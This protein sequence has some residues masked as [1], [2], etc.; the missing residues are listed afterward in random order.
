M[1]SDSELAKRLYYE[2]EDYLETNLANRRFK[3]SDIIPLINKLKNN[4]KFK[5]IK[6]GTS[7]EGRDIFLISL[8]SGKTKIF[9]WSQMHGDEATATMAIFDILNFL[10]SKNGFTELIN[11]FEKKLTI[12]FMPMLNPDGAEIFQRRNALGID[13]NRD[14]A[15][16]QSDEAKILMKYLVELKAD[17]GFNLHDQSTRYSVGKTFKPVTISF[18]AP[19]CDEKGKMNAVRNDA[20]RLI[21]KLYKL[22]SEFIP[23][24]IAKYSDE[25]EP[26]AFGDFSQKSGT[27]TILLESGGWKNDPEKQFI[28]KLNFIAL[29]SSFKSLAEKS[30]KVEK[31]SIYDSIPK[32]KEFLRDVIFRNISVIRNGKKYLIDLSVNLEEVNTRDSKGFYYTSVIEDI[33]DLSALFGYEDHDFKGLTLEYGKTYTEKSYT[34]EELLCL[35]FSQFYKKGF[36]NVLIKSSEFREFSKYPINLV[37][38]CTIQIPNEI[39]TNL[40]A[41][42]IFREK[43]QV[44]Y[45]VVNGF[46][47]SIDNF[48]GEIKNGIV[49]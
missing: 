22:L 14:A 36:T 5:V 13:I 48:S 8:G 18:L 23:G 6:A 28:R 26:R 9:L 2:H 49:Y 7:T 38:D 31:I 11:E 4:N 27:S 10:S 29:L 21:A 32:N 42:L 39:K 46:L 41:N 30:Y 17:F 24:H 34:D 40:P 16:L 43:T 44:K 33:G 20:A 35:D 19:P 1:I 3:H 25:Y 47:Y 15:S 37:K 45:A 12:Y